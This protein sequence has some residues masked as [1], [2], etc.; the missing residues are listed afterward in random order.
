MSS[1]HARA[2][3]TIPSS[4]DKFNEHNVTSP[5]SRGPST[6]IAT[7]N[8]LLTPASHEDNDGDTMMED[9][10][11]GAPY[12]RRRTSTSADPQQTLPPH[13]RTNG[14]ASD[15]HMS[16]AGAASLPNI[17]EI[18]SNPDVGPYHFVCEKR[19][20]SPL[21]SLLSGCRCNVSNESWRLT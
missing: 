3:S 5:N 8:S 19:S 17:Q 21:P 6:I 20:L 11:N 18:I 9:A 12:K 1:N 16:D 2:D 7:N 4:S 10:V 14:G 13:L 15:E